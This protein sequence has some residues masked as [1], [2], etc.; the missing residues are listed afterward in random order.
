MSDVTPSARR[1]LSNGMWAMLLLAATEGALFGTLLATYF[2]LRFESPQWPPVGI[3]APSVALPLA[4]TGVLVLS[5]GPMLLA[6]R[7]A[8]RGR[9]GAAWLLIALALLVQGGYLAWQIVLYAQDVRELSPDA[10]AY[11]SIYLTLLGVHHAHVAVG[12]LLG[13]W[14]LARLVSGLTDY[15]V[16]AVRVVALYWAFVSLVAVL[17]V[18]TQVSPS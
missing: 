11:G 5:T 3:E 8:R 18:A 7:A 14:L 16:V 15:R 10:T 13:L 12:I 1:T 9:A 17:V 4:L 2:Y 6:A